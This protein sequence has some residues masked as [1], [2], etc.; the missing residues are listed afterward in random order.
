MI[1]TRGLTLSKVERLRQALHQ[2]LADEVVPT[3]T[4]AMILREHEVGRAD[5]MIACDVLE[6]VVREFR[7]RE[8]DAMEGDSMGLTLDTLAFAKQ[9]EVS[10]ATQDAGRVQP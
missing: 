3:T 2:I 1:P 8:S 6:D 5:A 4:T 7:M 9:S 10:H